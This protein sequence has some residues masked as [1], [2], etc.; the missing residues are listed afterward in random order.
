MKEQKASSLSITVQLVT[1]GD[2]GDP[3]LA[4]PTAQKRQSCPA[5]LPQRE[6]E[7]FTASDVVARALLHKAGEPTLLGKTRSVIPMVGAVTPLGEA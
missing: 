3:T 6:Q 2:P 4:G 5:L 1:R 7:A